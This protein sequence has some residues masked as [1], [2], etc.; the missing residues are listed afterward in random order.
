MSKLPALKARD[1]INILEGLGFKRIRTKGSHISLGIS[2][3]GQPWYLA[4]AARILEGDYYG[5]YC[6]K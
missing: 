2:M 5:G 6:T 1:L 3:A 4:M